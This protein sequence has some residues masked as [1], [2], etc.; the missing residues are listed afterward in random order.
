LQALKGTSVAIARLVATIKVV[1]NVPVVGLKSCATVNTMAVQLVKIN[2][3]NN[4]AFFLFLKIPRYIIFQI[5]VG[6]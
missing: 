4:N 2:T 6:I 5:V 1:P 3:Y